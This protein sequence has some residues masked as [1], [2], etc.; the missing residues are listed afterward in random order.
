[1]DGPISCFSSRYRREKRDGAIERR[2][3]GGGGGGGGRRICG[4]I[5]TSVSNSNESTS[6]DN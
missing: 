2:G 1:M 5:N 4:A 6:I 3:G